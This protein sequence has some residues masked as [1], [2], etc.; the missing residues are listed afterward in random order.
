M[1]RFYK[2]CLGPVL[3]LQSR[4]L[5][6]TALRLPEAAGPREGSIPSS[7]LTRP[8]RLLFLGDSSAAGLASHD[9][10][11]HSRCKLPNYWPRVWMCLSSGNCLPNRV[12]THSKL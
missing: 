10:N 8:L 12:L 1:L 7:N 5:R 3:L 4:H 9:R 11:R 2:Y 6:K